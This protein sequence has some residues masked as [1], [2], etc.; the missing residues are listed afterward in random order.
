VR[1]TSASD[2]AASDS[3]SVT[4]VPVSGIPVSG[5]SATGVSVTGVSVSLPA[6]I[7]RYLLALVLVVTGIGHLTFARVGFQGQVPAW[8]PLDP[9]FVVLASGVVELAFAAG[10][11]L[12]RRWRV[13]VGWL[14][15]AFFIAIFPGNISQFVTHTDSLGLDSDVARGVRLVFQPLLVVVALWSTGAWKWWRLRRQARREQ[16]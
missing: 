5:V 6:T 14:L 7:A 2:S 4:G 16:S 11:I 12:L 10:L 13:A 8:V 1:P 9:D 3:V 15:A